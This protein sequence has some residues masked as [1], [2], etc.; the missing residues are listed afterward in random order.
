M[1]CVLPQNGAPVYPP[2]STSSRS[3]L[4]YLRDSVAAYFE[5]NSIP[6]TVALVGLKYRSFT[7]NQNQPTNANRVVFIPGEFD[8][9]NALKPRAYGELTRKTRNATS[10]VNPRELL[11]WERPIT[12]S[13]WSAPLP[14]FP[15]SEQGSIAV[16]ENLL[17]QVVRAT[18]NVQINNSGNGIP[19]SLSASIEWGSVIIN[20][21][22]TE[23]AFGVELLVSAIQKGPLF[24]VTLNYAQATPALKVDIT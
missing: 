17:E 19:I 18:Y 1:T 21:P 23:N 13:I 4:V 24:D 12:L 7:L 20:S 3:G 5:T 9:G 22:P 16:V 15:E 6:A 8:G 11:H 10:V 2:L 14:G